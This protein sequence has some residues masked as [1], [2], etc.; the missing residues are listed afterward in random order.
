MLRMIIKDPIYQQVNNALRDLI[1]GDEYR[2]GDKFLTERIICARYDV[3]RATANKALSNLVSE[4]IL[5]FKKGVGTFVAVKPRTGEF[6][7]MTSFT[8]NARRAGLQP[9]TEV[10]RFERLKARDTNPL[11]T[12]QLKVHTGDE[13][14]RIERLRKANGVPMILEDRYVVAHYCPDLLER[15]LCGS[16]YALFSRV[17]GLVVTHADETIQAVI[18]NDYQADLLDVT[19]GA[20]GLVVSAVGYLET[21]RPLWWE[22][23]V[24]KPDGFEFRCEVNTRRQH[25]TLEGRVLLKDTD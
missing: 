17:Y 11:V 7:S 22:T 8:E 12:R 14:Y 3:S 1:A 21:E 15:S 23:T 16:L 2:V 13:L 10:L 5:R 4:G 18:L 9:S 19:S 20:A 25:Q 6:P 24:H